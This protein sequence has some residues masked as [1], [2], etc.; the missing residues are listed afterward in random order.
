M[1]GWRN[2]QTRMI[3]VHM[4][5]TMGVQ[6]PPRACFKSKDRLGFFATL[7]YF[8]WRIPMVH[9]GTPPFRIFYTDGTSREHVLF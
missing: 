9:R 6:F 1:R 7:L 2:W 5:N 4:G 8:I 3:Q